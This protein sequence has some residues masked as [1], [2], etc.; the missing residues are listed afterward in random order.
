MSAVPPTTDSTGGR[1][2]SPLCA[3]SCLAAEY[4]RRVEMPLS[5][6][7]DYRLQMFAVPLTITEGIF[8]P[9]ESAPGEAGME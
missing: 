9:Q 6:L 5:R 3:D 4:C 8:D 1:A 7:S 2:V